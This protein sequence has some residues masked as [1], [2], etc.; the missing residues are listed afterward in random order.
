MK[1]CACS[2]FQISSGALAAFFGLAACSGALS[3]TPSGVA[4][5][6]A[7]TYNSG[8]LAP[9]VRHVF[10]ADAVFNVVTIFGRVG[11]STLS[12]FNEPQG[13]TTDQFATLYVANTIAEN[14]EEFAK[15]YPKVPTATIP[16]PG[17]WPVDVAVAKDGAVAAI[18]IC[19][20]SGSQ[21][22]GPGSVEIF[23]SNRASSPC[24]VVSGGSKISRV[25]W[26][27][28]DAAGRL[29]VAGVNNYTTARIGVIAGGCK[30]TSLNV[31]SPTTTIHFVAGV[32]VDLQGH[33]AV[34]D[35]QGFSGLPSIDVFAP[36]RHGSRLLNLLSHATLNSSTIVSSFALT[37]D[38]T[39]LY[40][41]EPHYSL[42]Y[43]YPSGGTALEQLS[44]PGGGD[45]IEGVAVTPAELP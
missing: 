37:K 36:P 12:G 28:F 26:G 39:H 9:G 19:K 1:L 16:T 35:S 17:E 42:E 22:G 27:A 44:P 34:V 13:I 30:A 21:C 24:A 18:I 45:L 14:V 8:A 25:L 15:P 41:A 4:A 31:L 29:Y 23:A 10:L 6:H 32:Q 5:P 40:T 11:T 20:A 3:P 38:G 2:A 43:S 7:A 33:I